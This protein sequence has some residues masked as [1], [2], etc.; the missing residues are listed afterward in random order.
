MDDLSVEC[1]LGWAARERGTAG[2]SD[3]F[4]AAGRM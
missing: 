2:L 1:V 4:G 3:D